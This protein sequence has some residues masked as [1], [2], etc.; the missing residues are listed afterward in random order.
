MDDVI[1]RFRL[2]LTLN[3]EGRIG[4]RFSYRLI[5]DGIPLERTIELKSQ[6][7][8]D[9]SILWLE[10]TMTPFSINQ[11][12]EGQLASAVFRANLEHPEFRVIRELAYQQFSERLMKAK[13]IQ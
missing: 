12:D 7:V 6:G 1:K 10:T 5:L 9:R 13:L 11:L 4:V 3:H 8:R 2:P